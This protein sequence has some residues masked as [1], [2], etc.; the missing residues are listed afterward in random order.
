M[1]ISGIQKSGIFMDFPVA[2]L[3]LLRNCLWAFAS[4][5]MKEPG[6][7]FEAAVES[8]EQSVLAKLRVAPRRATAQGPL[9]SGR[10]FNDVDSFSVRT[11]RT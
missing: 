8:I 5:G 10:H 4:L 2:V 7:F 1:L 6:P 9:R 11:W 3:Q